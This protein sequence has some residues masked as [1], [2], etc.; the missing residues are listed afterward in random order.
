MCTGTTGQDGM[1]PN[2]SSDIGAAH[3]RWLTLCLP[4]VVQTQK[5]ESEL[6]ITLTGRIKCSQLHFLTS[7]VLNFAFRYI[8]FVQLGTNEC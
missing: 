5:S 1:D 4:E 3:H 7:I 6:G 2:L 8:P